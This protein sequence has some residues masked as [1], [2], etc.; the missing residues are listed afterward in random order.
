MANMSYC[1][2]ENTYNDLR[3]AYDWLFE[4]DFTELSESERKYLIKL[5]ALCGKFHESTEGIKL[6]EPAQD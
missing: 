2:F 4:K 6:P 3:E 1:R 5:S